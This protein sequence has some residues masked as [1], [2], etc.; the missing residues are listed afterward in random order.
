LKPILQPTTKPPSSSNT[1]TLRP[2]SSSS[3]TIPA[4]VLQ[5]Q[6]QIHGNA[7]RQTP[8]QGDPL[9]GMGEGPFAMA[10]PGK[11]GYRAG[12]ATP[13]EVYRTVVKP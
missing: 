4:A 7:G 2:S 13:S 10:H 8:N 6:A 5:G 11:E 9:R 12:R 3:N 1:N